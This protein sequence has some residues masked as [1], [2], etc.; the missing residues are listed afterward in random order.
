MLIKS[1]SDERYQRPKRG[2]CGAVFN[3]AR[4]GR[5]YCVRRWEPV[6]DSVCARC[7]QREWPGCG[8]R[9]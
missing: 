7:D 3:M 6:E 1:R 8:E 9:R 4:D 2:E 5:W